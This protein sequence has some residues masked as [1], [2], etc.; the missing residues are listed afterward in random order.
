MKPTEGTCI[1]VWPQEAV[2][3][4]ISPGQD[5]AKI[6]FRP[7]LHESWRIFLP[8]YLEPYNYMWVR[9]PDGTV[10]RN[11]AQNSSSP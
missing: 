10:G 8:D 5:M 2:A 7:S 1:C 4:T 6:F 11:E 3:E 9:V